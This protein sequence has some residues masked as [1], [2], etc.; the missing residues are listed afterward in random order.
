MR[1][2]GCCSSGICALFGWGPWARRGRR[3]P[4]EPPSA[5]DMAL[6]QSIS[7]RSLVE[8]LSD[9]SSSGPSCSSFS[10]Q[11][12][13]CGL[14]AFKSK[15]VLREGAAGGPAAG[16]LACRKCL[17]PDSPNQDAALLLRADGDVTLCG[18]F[19][20]HGPK[21]HEVAD[22]V[23]DT[24]PRLVVRDARFGGDR[25]EMHRVLQEAFWRTQA[26]ISALDHEGRL[27]AKESGTTATVAVHDRRGGRLT[28][29]HAGDSACVLGRG[30]TGGRC[31]AKL[32]TTAHRPGLGQERQRIE[33]AG[34]RVALGGCG[35]QRVYAREGGGPGLAVSRT[36]GDLA[37]HDAC[38]VTAQPATLDWDLEAED[39]VLL[40]GSSGLWRFVEPRE[41]MECLGAYGA[42]EAQAAAERLAALALDNWIREDGDAVDPQGRQGMV[43]DIT[44]LVIGLRDS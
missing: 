20:G 28:V 31:T 1:D 13:A 2:H 10:T 19:D 33:R 21:G 27:D 40:L 42:E 9:G 4:P 29:A 22:F 23:R 12:D 26:M 35:G 38:G 37:S 3:G 11:S 41:A 43:Y 25:R 6:L 16:G 34:G 14:T 15:P 44:V 5:E 39:Q 17:R 36:L 18:V 7:E 30:P 32:L 8:M 24:L